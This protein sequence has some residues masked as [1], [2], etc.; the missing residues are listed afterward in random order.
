MRQAGVPP[1]RG[2]WRRYAVLLFL[3]YTLALVG[4]QEWHLS[5]L[6]GETA[7]VV[8]ELRRA[9]QEGLEVVYEYGRKYADTPLAVD[10]AVRAI[11][12]AMSAGAKR[13]VMERFEVDMLRD[14]PDV[15]QKLVAEVGM[16]CLV[17]EADSSKF[18]E[19]HVWLI[20]TL[21]PDVN[22]GNVAPGHVLRLEQFRR[23]LGIPVGY[24]FV[25]EGACR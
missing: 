21:G 1:R 25:R 9:R 11:S 24:R 16:G 15:L 17:L 12:E 8:A 14:N 3:G 5:R 23:G 19:Y 22:I 13:V 20:E 10:Q 18:P 4:L 6:G 7:R 2:R